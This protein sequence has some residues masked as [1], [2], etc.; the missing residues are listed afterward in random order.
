MAKEI[1]QEKKLDVKNLI[2]NILMVWKQPRNVLNVGQLNY[3][4]FCIK[5]TKEETKMEVCPNYKTKKI[6]WHWKK[7]WCDFSSF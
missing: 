5:L 1:N 6:D 2:K 7:E 3:W 4:N